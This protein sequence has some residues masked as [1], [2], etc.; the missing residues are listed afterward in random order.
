MKFY[1]PYQFIPFKAPDEKNLTPYAEIK[2]GK[3][4]F[5]RHDRWDKDAYSGRIICKLTTI[6]PLVVGAKQDKG[7]KEDKK[8]GIIGKAGV[9]HPYRDG[10]NIPANSLRGMLASIVETISHSSMR[11][12]SSIEQHHYFVRKPYTETPRKADNTKVTKPSYSATRRRPVGNLYD[13]ISHIDKN[14]LPWSSDR[15]GE[16]SEGSLTPAEA[17]FGVVED[18]PKA[19]AR[20]LGSR[21]RFYDATA[22]KPIT[23][24]H[25]HKPL[26]ILASPKPPSPSM[27][28]RTKDGEYIA[29]PDLNLNNKSHI[30]NGRKRYLAHPDWKVKINHKNKWETQ[31]TGNI[32]QKLKCQ[33]IPANACFWFHIDF[34][35]LSKDE[36]NLLR[37]A[38]NPGENFQH[39][40]GLGKPLGLGQI[41]VKE[42]ALFLIDRKTRYSQSGLFHQ[43]YSE[44][45]GEEGGIP[46]PIYPKE[47]EFSKTPPITAVD[48]EC[49]YTDP[50][51]IEQLNQLGHLESYEKDDKGHYLSVCYPFTESD[52][53]KESESYKHKET[54]G[55][56]WFCDNDKDKCQYLR[57]ILPGR[58]LPPLDSDT[59]EPDISPP[60]SMNQ[61]TLKIGGIPPKNKR[62]FN[63]KDVQEAVQTQLSILQPQRVNLEKGL[64]VVEISP[65]KLQ[66]LFNQNDPIPFTVKQHE[67]TLRQQPS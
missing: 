12:L 62:D 17:L 1:N 65:D 25:N 63:D 7:V 15:D 36:L 41:T 27:Y 16:E 26:K 21:L 59:N 9:V 45:S 32:D 51:T 4:R 33:P 43:H 10:Q 6:S 2:D 29:K 31:Q 42:T 5:V 38:I 50:E 52:K 20:N 19:V 57:E 46:N 66:T 44:W 67:M 61:Q 54:E 56:E 11:V 55:Y 49:K 35:N 23:L 53:H 37:T 48:M 64:L 60:A 28:F 18:H 3:T 24:E 30:P 47:A 58:Q 40:L 39:Q 14:L 13:S 22:E 34:E 8:K